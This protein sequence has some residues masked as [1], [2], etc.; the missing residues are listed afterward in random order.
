MSSSQIGINPGKQ[1]N[2]EESKVSDIQ[3]K[4]KENKQFYILS[5]KT[6]CYICQKEMSV[7]YCKSFSCQH[8]ICIPCISKLILRENFNFLLLDDFKERDYIKATVNCFC[9]KGNFSAELN[10]IQRELTDSVLYNRPKELRCQKHF[11]QATYFC[12]NCNN[13]ICDKCNEEH[14]NNNQKNRKAKKHEIIKI[15]E[16]KKSKN[17]FPKERLSDIESNISEAKK[18][19]IEFTSDEQQVIVDEIDKIIASLNEIKSNYIKTFKEKSDFINRLLDFIL[20]T[21]KIFFK[22]CDYD[23]AELSMNNCRLIEGITN[24]FHNIEYVPKALNFCDKVMKE[25]EKTLDHKELLDFEYKFDFNYINYFSHQELIGHKSAVNCICVIDNRYIAS[26]SSDHT[27]KIWDTFNDLIKVKPIKTLDF[28]VDIVN[29]IINIDNGNHL[30][31]SGRDDKLCLWDVKEIL[32][33]KNENI[34]NNGDISFEFETKRIFPKKYIFSESIVVYSLLMLSNGKIVISGRDES[35]KIVDKEL[36]KMEIILKRNTNS[37]LTAA[38]FS[39]GILISGG[40]DGSVKI[41]DLNKKKCLD[42]YK[43]HKAQVNSVIKIRYKNNSLLS[44]SS[45]NTIKILNYNNDPNLI[46]EK[47]VCEGSLEGHKGPIYCL[48]ELLDGRIASGSSDWTIKIWN[49]NDKTCMQ[50]LLGHKS[51]IFS[52]AQLP[53]GRLISG[54]AD[55]MIYIWRK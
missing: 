19:F 49:L 16:C 12:L 29:S 48:L 37:V 21:Y 44:G 55:K 39:D 38:E 10:S 54:E 15:E 22:E 36:K 3:D 51:T 13:E 42:T 24:T 43:G 11:E 9:G 31:S 32:D 52:L 30:I 40:A 26:G 35:I 14:I 50:T 2:N 34:L 33:N 47:I 53:D 28:H 17:N 46:K 23:I 8:L 6:I 25:V 41:W 20:T 18:K 45:D 4:S 1:N 5:N 7:D 27:I